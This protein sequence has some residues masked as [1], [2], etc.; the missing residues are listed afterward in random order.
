MHRTSTMAV[1]RHWALTLALFVVFVVSSLVFT[2]AALAQNG[3]PGNAVGVEIDANNR[4]SWQALIPPR[5]ASS[6]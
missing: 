1:K 4:A 5:A 3:T 6:T 2:S